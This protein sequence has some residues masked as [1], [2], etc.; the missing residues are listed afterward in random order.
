MSRTPKPPMTPRYLTPVQVAE[1]L[2]ISAR[3]AQVMC[4]TGALPAYR[5]GGLYRVKPEDLQA[6]EE[7]S[8]LR[9]PG[10]R[11]KDYSFLAE[12]VHNLQ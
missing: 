8:K 11:K 2:G 10:R 5:F 6:Y 3:K 12:Q 7:K 1:Q 9:F 4:K